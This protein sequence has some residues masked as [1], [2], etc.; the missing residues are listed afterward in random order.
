M[1]RLL[2]LSGALVAGG[3]VGVVYFAGLWTTVRALPGTRNP[4][5]LVFVS[6]AV[7][8]AVAALLFVALAR[9]GGWSLIASALVGFTLA[10]V[11]IVRR[12]LPSGSPPKRGSP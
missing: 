4:A 9:T 6:F 3:V 1:T 10:R 8:F 2:M 11:V 7:R 5:F 12:L